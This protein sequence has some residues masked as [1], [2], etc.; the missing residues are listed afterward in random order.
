MIHLKFLSQQRLD[1]KPVKS[2]V[3]A[4]DPWRSDCQSAQ[5]LFY[6]LSLEKGEFYHGFEFVSLRGKA[7]HTEF[8]SSGS[9]KALRSKLRSCD[10]PLVGL[11]T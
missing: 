7:V 5:Q 8:F 11:V 2:I 10:I 1:L 3:V 6:N 9:R 4:L